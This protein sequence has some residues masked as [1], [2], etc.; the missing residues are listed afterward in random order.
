M[1]VKRRRKAAPKAAAPKRRSRRLSANGT[2]TIL[3]AGPVRRRRR[4]ST[5]S[6]N[7]A[8]IK[9]VIV[10]IVKAAAGGAAGVVAFNAMPDTMDYKVKAAIVAGAGGVV[11]VV[12][13]QP[14][15]GAGMAGAAGY[16]AATTFGK[17]NNIKLLSAPGQAT[18]YV[19]L[20]EGRP[21][22][23]MDQNG[24]QL[25]P[26][27]DLLYY[28]NGSLYQYRVSQMQPAN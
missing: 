5:M 7:T 2:R 25:F 21:Q 19:R 3:A 10:P 14:F 12:M 9:A 11:A 26:K 23:F 8:S 15:V 17:E 1:A 4:R 28:Q 6:A 20:S 16:L 13:K 27:G 18:T 24:N 22:V